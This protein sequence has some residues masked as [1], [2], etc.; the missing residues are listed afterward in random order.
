MWRS[1]WCTISVVLFLKF[2]DPFGSGKLIEF[3]VDYSHE[4][5][6]F[7]IIPFSFVG[8]IGGVMGGLF[9]KVNMTLNRYK[10]VTTWL[11]SDPGREVMLVALISCVFNYTIIYNRYCHVLFI[12]YFLF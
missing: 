2:L 1:F 9:I 12:Q 7:E 5:K 6:W 11:R 10:R 3:E 4:W 8:M